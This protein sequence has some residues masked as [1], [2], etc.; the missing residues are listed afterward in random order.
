MSKQFSDARKTSYYLGT[1]LMVIGGLMFFSGAVVGLYN[2]WKTLQQA[3]AAEQVPVSSQPD[4]ALVR[5]GAVQP[6]E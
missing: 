6:G 2:I 5:P 4:A 1:A 3:P